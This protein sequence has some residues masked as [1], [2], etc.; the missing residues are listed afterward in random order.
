MEEHLR[1]K[2]KT[3]DREHSDGEDGPG[4]Q[5]RLVLVPDR[6][7]EEEHQLLDQQRDAD[8]VDGAAVDVLVD[9][10]SLVG[11]VDVVSVHGVLDQEVGKAEGGDQGADDGVGHS[12][13]KHEQHPGVVDAEREL[14]HDRLPHAG[15]LSLGLDRAEPHRVHEELGEPDDLQPSPDEGAGRHVVDEEGAVVREEDALPVDPAAP[16]VR[17]VGLGDDALHEGP[18]RRLPDGGEDEH[19]D[20]QQPEHLPHDPEIL[21]GASPV[22]EHPVGV[23]HHHRQQR[24]Q[25]PELNTFYSNILNSFVLQGMVIRRSKA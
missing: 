13:R 8:T 14:Q 15:D 6:V 10:G 12:H 3:E 24:G 5:Q 21:H 1:K 11:E 19:H 9:L 25:G 22:S 20:Q 23:G 2:Q 17:G 16:G 4:R 18:D 7:E